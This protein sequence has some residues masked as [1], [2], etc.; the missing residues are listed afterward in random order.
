MQR[1]E[2]EEIV[3]S[4]KEKMTEPIF[5]ALEKA[6]LTKDDIDKCVNAG[7]MTRSSFIENIVKEFFGDDLKVVFCDN[8]FESVAI[9]A[10]YYG[11]IKKNPQIYEGWFTGLGDSNQAD[12]SF[13]LAM[14]TFPGG[15]KF[16][17]TA[18]TFNK[19]TSEVGTFVENE[20]INFEDCSTVQ[21]EN[22]IYA[23]ARNGDF[24]EYRFN[25][26]AS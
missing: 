17:R 19:T 1:S 22:S 5:E 26:T 21:V 24:K 16:K 6:N 25:N 8:P 10:A 2:F 9:G 23:L 7:G 18:F 3:Q 20:R 14:F 15:D 11:L 13:D 4:F 12:Q